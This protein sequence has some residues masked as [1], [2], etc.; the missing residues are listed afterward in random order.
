[1]TIPKINP[2]MKSLLATCIGVIVALFLMGYVYIGRH[3]DFGDAAALGG[4]AV[5]FFA[6]NGPYP[7]HCQP[8]SEFENCLK[9]IELRN[10]ARQIIWFGNS[11]LHAINQYKNGEINAPAMLAARLAQ[12]GADLVTFSHGNANLE[13]HFVIFEYLRTRIGIKQIIL[14]V[15]FDD[16]REEGLIDAVAVLIR[17]EALKKRLAQTS[18]GASLLKKFDAPA[19]KREESLTPQQYVEKILDGLLAERLPLWKARPEIRGDL[20]I[21]LYRLRN[22]VFG[23]TPNTKRKL[24]LSRYTANM[25]ALEALLRDASE[26]G[27]SVLMYVAP[28]GINH[29]ERPYVETEYQRFKR[30]AEILATRYGA[31]F[32]NFEDLVPEELWGR[33]DSTSM[34]AEA[35]VDF[36]HFTSAGH[37]VLADCIGSLLADV[38]ITDRKKCP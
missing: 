26:A 4:E 35:E 27:I 34:S 29:G 32:R 16:F 19:T 13:E 23:I 17:D 1:M 8:G 21:G 31:T 22:A 30:E 36:M 37:A 18:I 20:F 28:V 6:S 25:G 10:R 38:K 7:I 2:G 3:T 9:G 15:V 5:S 14:P 11:Q 12:D 24:I 33:K